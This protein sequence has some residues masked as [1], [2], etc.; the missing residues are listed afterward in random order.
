LELERELV[1]DAQNGSADAFEK[2]VVR[3]RARVFR[4][5]YNITRHHQDTEDIVQNTFLKAFKKLSLFRG[6]SSFSTWLTSIAVNECLMRIRRRR[7]TEISINESIEPIAE[8]VPRHSIEIFWLSPEEHC[9]YREFRHALATVL[10]RLNP[11]SRLVF[12]LRYI[13]GLSTLETAEA[14][15]LTVPAVKTRLYRART[16][17]RRSLGRFIHQKNAAGIH[18][19]S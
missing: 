18:E 1:D 7:C 17:V 5:A 15:N 11:E 19:S 14:L 9:S 12:Q 8:V 10:R 6:D 13:E 16:I 4:V 2:L 3:Y